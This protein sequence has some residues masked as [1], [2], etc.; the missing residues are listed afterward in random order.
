MFISRAKY[1]SDVGEA[2]TRG[3]EQG[4][5]LARKIRRNYEAKGQESYLPDSHAMNQLEEFSLLSQQLV[6]IAQNKGI[7]LE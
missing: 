1:H 7:D 4:F 6:D 5:E 3:L 2:Y